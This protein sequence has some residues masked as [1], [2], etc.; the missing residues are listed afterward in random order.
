MHTPFIR[1]H[2]YLHI[3]RR[4]LSYVITGQIVINIRKQDA[5][6][7]VDNRVQSHARS[8][9]ATQYPHWGAKNT[10]NAAE[11]R[12]CQKR[13]LG[14]VRSSYSKNAPLSRNPTPRVYFVSPLAAHKQRSPYH[15]CSFH[16]FPTALPSLLPSSLHSPGASAHG[17][18]NNNLSNNL[19]YKPNKRLQH[20]MTLG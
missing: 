6:L 7:A 4:I 12:D 10:L 19:S 3:H 17:T 18:H 16:H 20:G 1:R 15:G 13:R 11:K 9:W 5:R 2:A 14:A 8:P